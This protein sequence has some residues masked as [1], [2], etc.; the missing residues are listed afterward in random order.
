MITRSYKCRKVF[1]DGNSLSNIGA[2]IVYNEYRYPITAYGLLTGARPSCHP[3]GV[4]AKRTNALTTDFLTKILPYATPNDIVVILEITN[5]ARS[6][7]A[8]Q[9]MVD[10]LQAYCEQARSYGLKVVVCTCPAGKLTTDPADTVTRELEANV[11]IRN[12]WQTFADRLADIGALPEFDSE[13]DITNTTYYNADQVHMT[14]TG[15]DTM[16]VPVAA[17]VQ[18]LL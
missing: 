15:Y 3:C 11:I 12:T 18:S 13:A 17:A 10:N 9:T 5:E 8:A 16:A 6:G 14:T 4:S 1:F 7:F 2:G